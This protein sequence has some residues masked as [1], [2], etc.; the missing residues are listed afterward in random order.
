M[1]FI[2]AGAENVLTYINDLLLHSKNHSKHLFHLANALDRVGKA[3][4]RL[5]LTKCIFGASK[6]EYLG[7]TI[8]SAG[9]KPG[10][11]KSDAMRSAP[12]PCTVKEVC[13]FNGLANYFQQYI[14]QF[15]T[16]AAPLF[17]LIKQDSNWKGGTLPPAALA[18]FER[19]RKEILSR[20]LMA[21]PNGTGTYHLFVDACLGDASNSGSLGAVLLQDQPDGCCRPIGYASRRLT[22]SERKYPIF[23]A[24]MQAAVF[25]M[26]YFHH[27][28]LPAKFKLYTDHKPMCKLSSAHAKT[29]D[30]LQVKMTELHLELQNIEGKDNVVADFLSRYHGMNVA[31][32]DEDYDKGRIARINSAF[33][34]MTHKDLGHPVQTVAAS[35]FRVSMLQRDDPILSLIIANKN[36]PR[37]TFLLPT[38]GRSEHSRFPATIIDNVLYV[39]QLPRKGF[40]Q[41]SDLHMAVPRS[42][43]DEI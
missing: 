25:A 1:D 27:Y 15:A 26:N 42:M 40:L 14:V 18:S 22:D 12:I 7:H 4:L 31:V 41:T 34:R 3:N 33:A 2:M 23:L 11:D 24:E 13:S 9:I 6:V 38:F 35:P 32:G 30:R 29:L 17:A 28:L 43:R 19:L 20:P 10:T 5:N 36:I 21:F 37:S 8:T 16:K 39:K